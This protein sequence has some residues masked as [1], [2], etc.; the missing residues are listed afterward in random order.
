MVHVEREEVRPK[1]VGDDLERDSSS[2]GESLV[3]ATRIQPRHPWAQA[4]IEKIPSYQ[5][6]PR[7]E[8]DIFRNEFGRGLRPAS[9]ERQ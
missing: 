4:Q 2:G 6:H 7:P 8:S 5:E 9:H 1:R 3:S